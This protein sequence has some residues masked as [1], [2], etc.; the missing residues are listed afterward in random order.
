MVVYSG[1]ILAIIM[2]TSAGKAVCFTYKFPL[3]WICDLL[4][5]GVTLC[6]SWS[7]K[8]FYCVPRESNMGQKSGLSCPQVVASAVRLVWLYAWST[9]TFSLQFTA[10]IKMLLWQD[11][12]SGQCAYFLAYSEFRGF[13]G[14][15]LSNVACVLQSGRATLINK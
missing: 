11:G 6:F 3:R 13:I 5:R 8:D 15:F 14:Q 4:F 12:V 1:F 9:P 10:L 2:A 7:L